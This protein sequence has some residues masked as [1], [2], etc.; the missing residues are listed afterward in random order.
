MSYKPADMEPY[1]PANGTEG[2]IFDAEFCDRCTHDAA[3]R[4][5]EALGYDN[6][7]LYMMIRQAGADPKPCEILSNAMVFGIE[8]EGYPRDTWVHFGGRPCCLAFRDREGGGRRSQPPEPD[9]GQLDMFAPLPVLVFA[10]A[11]E[12]AP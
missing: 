7:R 11:P 1:R 9:P 12:A 3:W 10:T 5:F 6:P 4:D 8:D 2:E